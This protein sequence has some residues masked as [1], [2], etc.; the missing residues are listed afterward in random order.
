MTRFCTQKIP[1]L[2]GM[3][4]LSFA[5]NTAKK[6][7]SWI[8]TTLSPPSAEGA[9]NAENGAQMT[10]V[11]T[12][13]IPTQFVSQ[14]VS[15]LVSTVEKCFTWLLETFSGAGTTIASK[16]ENRAR[17]TQFC[18][19]N[20][21]TLLLVFS[22]YLRIWWS[23]ARHDQQAKASKWKSVLGCVLVWV[24]MISREREPIHI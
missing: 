6:C 20:T 2:F 1:T 3:Q 19:R 15:F 24:S 18:T 17:M 12:R 22:Q 13:N 4:F 9:C 23:H 7:F 21:P 14:L 5:I 11:C 10:P 8:L 16:V